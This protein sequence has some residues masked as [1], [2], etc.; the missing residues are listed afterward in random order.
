MRRAIAVI[1]LLCAAACSRRDA[2]SRDSTRDTSRAADSASA[3]TVPATTD[4]SDTIVPVTTMFTLSSPAFRNGDI[5][6]RAYT[7]EGANK[8]PQLVWTAPPPHSAS[9]ALIVE[10]PDA[11]GGTFIHWVLYD[12]PGSATSLPEGVPKAAEL[13][14]LGGAKQGRTSFG[15]TGYGGPCPPPGPPHH[16]H[17]RLFALDAKLG[18]SAGATRDQVAAAMQGHELA[19]AELVGLYARSK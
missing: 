18:L 10:D 14:Q 3:R 9:L 13:P 19:R 15:T 17:F 12:L 7:C 2:S 6:P 1:T 11:P 16:Y 8:S 4:T 5:I